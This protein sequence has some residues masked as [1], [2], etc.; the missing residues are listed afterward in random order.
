MSQSDISAITE[1]R[2]APID[3]LFVEILTYIFHMC[4]LERGCLFP[5]LDVNDR[6]IGPWKL[7]RVCS[8][9]RQIAN[10]TP[11][12]WT[13]LSFSFSLVKDPVS[14]FKVALEGSS[15]LSLDLELS[16]DDQYPI[17][18]QREIYQLAISHSWRWERLTITPNHAVLPFL[19]DIRARQLDR[20]SHL[21]VHCPE[22]WTPLPI[23][24][25]QDAPALQTI[26]PH[27]NYG[28]VRFELPWN[29]IV[30]FYDYTS[31]VE[32]VS[33]HH[34]ID[35]IQRFPNI[36][37]LYAPMMCSPFSTVVSIATPFVRTSLRDL[38]ACE[39]PILRSLVLP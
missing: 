22:L 8:L 39:G 13:R 19:S 30:E 15:C 28:G 27:H 16:P 20:L 18:V 7:G 1:R 37:T 11:T 25:F 4:V 6:K 9:W 38:T 32:S 23:D 24:A 17:D 3:R 21:V 35:M 26:K 12:L 36:E 14:R 5:R 33:M 2:A 29:N 34:V 10:K 31:S